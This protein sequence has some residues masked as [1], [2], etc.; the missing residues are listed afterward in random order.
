MLDFLIDSTFDVFS[1]HDFCQRTV[2]VFPF[3]PTYSHLHMIWTSQ[4][5]F[6]R[7]ASFLSMVLWFSG[8][9]LFKWTCNYEI[10]VL[11]LQIS[12]NQLAIWWSQIEFTG[13]VL[14]EPVNGYLLL[15]NRQLIPWNFQIQY[16][17]LHSTVIMR[18]AT[19]LTRWR[20]R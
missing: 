20:K 18:I 16:S 6:W 13:D 7:Q 17:Y 3:Y 1:G 11:Y 14:A 19:L 9:Y 10:T 4:G 8:S 12:R 2:F 5:R 15:L